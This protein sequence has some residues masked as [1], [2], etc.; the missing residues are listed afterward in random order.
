MRSIR[1]GGGAI[2]FPRPE[3][4]AALPWTDEDRELVADG[5]DTQFVGSPGTVVERLRPA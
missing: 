4:A 5:V 1:S 3:Q 2:P